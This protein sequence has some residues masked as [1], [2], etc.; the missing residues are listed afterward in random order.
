MT[1]KPVPDWFYRSVSGGLGMLLVLHLPGAPGHETIEYTEGV[2]VEVLW[3]ANIGWDEAL[4]AP[5]LHQGFLRLARQA[6]RWPAPRT[7]LEML[8]QRPER[9]RLPKPQMS[10]AERERNRQRL[11]EMMAELGIRSTRQGGGDA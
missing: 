11:A 2:W 4:D 5:R 1:Q 6:D 3:S 8:P 10:R 9:K 7:L